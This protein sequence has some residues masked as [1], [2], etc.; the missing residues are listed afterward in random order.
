VRP[1]KRVHLP[2]GRVVA[3]SARAP[4]I[5]PRARAPKAPVFSELVELVASGDLALSDGAAPV[6]P[7]GLDLRDFHALRAIATHLGWLAEDPVDIACR[8]C[9]AMMAARPCASIEI[10]PF[11]DGELDDPD[12]D[13]TL[14]LS[15]SHSIPDVALPGGRTAT[16]V[17]LRRV[18]AAEAAPLHRA[19][20]R[21]RLVVSEA[22]VRAMGIEALGP[23]RDPRAIAAALARCS[24][25]AWEAIGDC[26]LRAHYSP[27]L[28]AVVLCA[29]CGARNDVDAPYE[30]EFEP[31]SASP[32]SND[33]IFPDFDAFA[34]HAQASFASAA[35]ADAATIRLVVEQGVPECDDG[36]E[37]LLGSYVPPAGDVTAPVGIATVTL[38]YRSFR[39]MW[40]ED[41]RYDWRAEVDETVE[42]ELEHH[43]GWRSGYDPMDDE[44]RAAIVRDHGRI[45]GRREA[46]RR[47]V[48]ALGADL[49]GFVARTWPIWLIVAAISVALS[50]CER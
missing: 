18:T 25:A 1:P 33:E 11:A 19:L 2:S 3:L 47:G 4:S 23:E 13:A 24:D 10:A 39:S 32:Q 46:A 35:G 29:D 26:F 21:R 8:N 28:G 12:L 45:V 48:A 5:P 16:D 9:E 14:D 6:D 7:A 38:Y 42:H 49:R 30:R 37:P 17:R 31:S 40:A 41:G 20:R 22:V 43:V 44:E 34:A 50:L 36:G 15:V 27:R